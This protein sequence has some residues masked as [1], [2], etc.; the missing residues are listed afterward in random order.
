MDDAATHKF[1]DQPGDTVTVEDVR[2]LKAQQQAL[3]TQVGQLTT[4]LRVQEGWLREMSEGIHR[5]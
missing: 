4:Q 2:M 1:T 3:A 5:Q